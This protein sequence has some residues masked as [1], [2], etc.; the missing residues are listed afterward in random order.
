MVSTGTYQDR[1]EKRDGAWKCLERI[2]DIDPNWPVT[3]FQPWID[4][5]GQ[6]FRAS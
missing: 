5:A 6:T 2:S 1:F 4:A 3:L